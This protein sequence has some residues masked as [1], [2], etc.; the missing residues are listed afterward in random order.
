M[1]EDCQDKR[2]HHI[3]WGGNDRWISST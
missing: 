3:L 2:R 1:R